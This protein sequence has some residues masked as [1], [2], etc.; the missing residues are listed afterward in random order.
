MS[1]CTGIFVLASSGVLEG[2]QATGPRALTGE[3]KGKWPGVKWGEG[4]WV[5]DGRG[6][7]EV[8]TS[9]ELGI[10][11]LVSLWESLAGYLACDVSRW[12]GRILC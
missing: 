5:R 4:R 10:A 3:L 11:F 7:G 12:K 6:K 9:G 2:K 8:W 1:V